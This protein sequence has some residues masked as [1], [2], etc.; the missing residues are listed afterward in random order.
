MAEYHETVLAG[1]TP[2]PLANYLKGLAILRLLSD[3]KDRSAVARWNGNLFILRSKLAKNQ[4][5]E[6]FLNDY[7]PTPII[8]PWNG[9]AGFLEGED[10]S[11]STRKGPTTIRKASKSTG[12]R[13]A[14]YRTI[15][16]EARN[17]QVLLDLDEVRVKRKEIESHE[18]ELK[19]QKLALPDD[20]KNE[21]KTL[22]AKEKKCK[23]Q[24]L[25]SL[26]AEMS[27]LFLPWLD[28]CVVLTGE[29]QTKAP[30]L[31]SGGNEGSMDFSI[32]HLGHLQ[33]LIDPCTDQPTSLAASTI[34]QALFGEPGIISGHG[35][36]GF[37]NPGMT[38]GPNMGTGFEGKTS[39]NPWNTV[40]MLE[41][42]IL[43]AAAVTKKSSSASGSF[44]SL[45]FIFETSRA[46]HGSIGSEEKSAS[47][48]WAPIWKPFTSAQELQALL[49][50]GRTTVGRRAGRNGLDM[51]R[52]VNLLGVDRGLYAFERY[53]FFERRGKGYSVA[54]PMG[55][56]LVGYNTASSLVDELDNWLSV[57]LRFEK[58][59]NVAKRFVNLRRALEEGLFVLA[60]RGK[61]PANVQ[62]VLER[63]GELQIAMSQSERARKE[64]DPIP[65]L[66]KHWTQAADDQSPAFHI[67]CALA[68]L[69][70]LKGQPLPVRSQLFPIHHSNG[71]KWLEKI[72]SNK[73]AQHKND[74]AC[75]I[76]LHITH[77][78]N[79]ESTLITLLQTRLSLPARLDFADKPLNSSAG[80]D[81]ADLMHFLTS[82]QTQQMDEKILNML[83]G[84][85]LCRV[86]KNLDKG[87]GQGEI[88]AAYA[89][90]K[91]ALVPNA[92]LQQLGLLQ[93]SEH[94][95]VA[96]PLVPKL[97]SGDHEQAKHA[98][99]IA[100][101]RLHSS[102]LKPI[103][104]SNQLPDLASIDPRRLAASLLIPLSFGATGALARAVL[105]SDQNSPAELR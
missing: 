63:L 1:C 42:I 75:R 9:R 48:F 67:A 78:R 104:P 88:H 30:L 5:R 60:S 13:F 45:P 68:S 102:G 47:E 80:V 22:K 10:A 17:V 84:L 6:F 86:P 20:E 49:S 15:L 66:S 36:P 35:N 16:D 87:A 33:E 32:N 11:K 64:V 27:D 29:E 38:N 21:L 52:S 19:G 90:C 23:S 14:G 26:R 4:I 100:W 71:N 73:G 2:T 12:R 44:A 34:D 97:A 8:S 59:K 61:A 25:L 92:T 65:Q 40:L 99:E 89:L 101:K 54:I 93:N 24:L 72:R 105:K 94:V 53:G 55:R 70:G 39:D 57:F 83:F 56:F 62:V 7:E 51:V 98:I 76:R 96:S 81:L 74:P 37:L 77:Q 50:E 82:T 91:L 28:A 31:G 79:L 41:G 18:R 85:S 95:P 103:M 58:G 46:G 43:F 3:Q 69:R